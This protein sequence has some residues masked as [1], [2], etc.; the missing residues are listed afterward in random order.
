MQAQAPIIKCFHRSNMIDF[1]KGFHKVNSESFTRT[2]PM[3][4]KLEQ[5]KLNLTFQGELI[6]SGKSAH[7]RWPRAKSARE[8]TGRERAQKL[9]LYMSPNLFSRYFLKIP[10]QKFLEF[11][12]LRHNEGA[13]DKMLASCQQSA[14]DMWQ[15]IM[16]FNLFF[17]ISWQ[18]M[19]WE[20][21][22]RIFRENKFRPPPL[23]KQPRQDMSQTIIF[24]NLFKII[25][26]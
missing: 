25:S 9:R 26:R 22:F 8:V 3:S 2:A 23:H 11:F 17:M 10:P 12:P 16:L 15:T 18:P 21:P 6:F 13:C 4:S 24:I 14:A 1:V 5:A 20:P 19:L 7:V